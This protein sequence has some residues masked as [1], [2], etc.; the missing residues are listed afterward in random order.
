MRTE[1][2]DLPVLGRFIALR[3][4]AFVM[5]NERPVTSWGGD[6]RPEHARNGP[7]RLVRVAEPFAMLDAP[8]TVAAFRA[9]GVEVPLDAAVFCL[10]KSASI[11]DRWDSRPFWHVNERTAAP[12]VGVTWDEART[13]CRTLSRRLGV[14]LRLPTEVEW[15]YACRAGTTSLYFWGDDVR[16]GDE[17]AWFDENSGMS[18]HAVRE[19]RCNPWGL[20]D[21]AGNVWEWC[22]PD[23]YQD[24]LDVAVMPVRGGSACHHATSGRSAHRFELPRLQRN[25]F[26][27]FRCVLELDA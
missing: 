2:I 9:A 22:A 13:F 27:G 16:R 15:E 17:Y 1:R 7:E 21:M 19:R 23:A 8:V 25:A 11:D 24:N 26:L 18:V 6:V 5:G 4:G 14:V 10:P 20:F 3:E 12:V